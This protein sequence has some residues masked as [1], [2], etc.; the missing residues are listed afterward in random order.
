MIDLGEKEKRK[1]SVKALPGRFSCSCLS[2][3]H[4]WQD[5][6]GFFLANMKYKNRRE[7]EVR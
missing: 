1:A 7:L 3:V 4:T 2:E 6:S 5:F